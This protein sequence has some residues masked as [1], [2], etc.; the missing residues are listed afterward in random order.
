MLLIITIFFLL[1]CINQQDIQNDFTEENNIYNENN[2][3]NNYYNEN[4]IYNENDLD[5]NYFNTENLF[6]IVQTD[7]DYSNFVSLYPNFNPLLEYYFILNQS[8]FENLKEDWLEDSQ[9]KVFIP[10]IETINL[11]ENTYF[12]EF[13]DTTNINNSL[14]AILDVK[15]NKSLKIISIIKMNMGA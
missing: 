14:V 3:D 9:K 2:L 15:E 5:N 11:N 4:T 10:I 1:G 12:V 6:R 8:E 7:E 13:N